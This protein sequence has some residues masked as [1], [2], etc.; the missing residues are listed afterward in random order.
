MVTIESS[1]GF[2]P[3]IP[4]RR[5]RRRHRTWRAVCECRWK[6]GL[7]WC[8]GRVPPSSPC[9]ASVSSCRAFNHRYRWSSAIT[10]VLFD[11]AEKAAQAKAMIDRLG[12]GGGCCRAHK[13]FIMRPVI[14]IPT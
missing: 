12:C 14:A 7:L 9:Y 10:I 2:A 6:R 11:T 3:G 8:S 4:C 13:I 1:T 5:C